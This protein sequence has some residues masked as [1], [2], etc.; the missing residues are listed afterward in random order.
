MD[1][2]MQFFEEGTYQTSPTVSMEMMFRNYLESILEMKRHF[3]SANPPYYLGMEDFLLREGRFFA[4][5][6]L[7]DWEKYT[8]GIPKHC[9]A[10]SVEIGVHL[11]GLTYCEGLVWSV[12]P[13]VHAWNLD[14][15]G[16]VVDL[17]LPVEI[18]KNVQGYWGV[19]FS[20]ERLISMLEERETY[21]PFID[22]Y[23]RDY[24]L[25]NRPW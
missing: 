3:V 2:K 19:E 17:T 23:E 20:L 15:D 5:P 13:I 6:D 7:N 25:Y 16:N 21:G 24:P 4:P 14:K 18:A 11:H 22:D 10:N 8:R 12:I 9:F 1:N